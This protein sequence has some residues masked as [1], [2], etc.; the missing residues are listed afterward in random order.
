MT[1]A[2]DV[3]CRGRGHQELVGVNLRGDRGQ[4]FTPGRSQAGRG[5]AR[6]QG[7]SEMVLDLLAGLAVS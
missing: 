3:G 7:E 6:S 2:P 5:N 1:F 4:Y